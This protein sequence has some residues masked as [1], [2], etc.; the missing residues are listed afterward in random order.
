[1]KHLLARL[2]LL[3][4]LLCMPALAGGESAAASTSAKPP[5]EYFVKAVY[6]YNF[7]KF[8]QWP[9]EYAPANNASINVCVVGKDPFG[10][11]LSAVEKASTDKLKLVIK[12]GVSDSEMKSCHLLFISTS[13]EAR[14]DSIIGQIQGRPV[15][16]VSEIKNFA[17]RGGVIGFVNIEKNI[18]LFTKDKLKLEI[19]TKSASNAHLKIDANLL[20]IAL[21]VIDK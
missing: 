1:M 20:E 10:E 18:G 2:A 17:S 11:D 15:L 12:R 13:E 19:N 6:L 8:V 4:G 3:Y 16:T 14:L 21:N 9:G 7:I 5:S